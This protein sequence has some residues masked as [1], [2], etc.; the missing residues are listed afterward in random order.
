MSNFNNSNINITKYANNLIYDYTIQSGDNFK[1]KSFSACL[2]PKID[3]SSITQLLAGI[4][5]ILTLYNECKL[6]SA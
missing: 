4:N 5:S 1:N 6:L 2:N 3:K